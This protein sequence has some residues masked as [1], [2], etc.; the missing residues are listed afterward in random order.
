MCH[1]SQVRISF[2]G[3][4]AVTPDVLTEAA[5]SH[6]EQEGYHTDVLTA[7]RQGLSS[8]EA[9]IS[10]LR[11]GA[12]TDL[13]RFLSKRFPAVTFWVWGMGEEPTDVWTRELKGGKV[14]FKR[15]PFT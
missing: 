12:I 10:D 15:G 11:S 8:G 7:L 1:F 14:A 2:E 3:D 5:K 13:F 9:E 6:I 4:E